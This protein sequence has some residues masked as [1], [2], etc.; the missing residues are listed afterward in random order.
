MRLQL[1]AGAQPRDAKQL[2][3]CSFR[4]L[5]KTW[6]FDTEDT[7]TENSRTK[8]APAAARIHDAEADADLFVRNQDNS[9]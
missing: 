5:G 2:S 3:F 6:S 1:R 7:P 8:T 9:T 4:D